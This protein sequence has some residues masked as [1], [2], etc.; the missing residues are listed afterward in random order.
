MSCLWPTYRYNWF[1]KFH[2]HDMSLW[3]EP[4]PGKLSD[5]DQDVLRGL[6]EYNPWK[7]TP[8]LALDL[9]TSQSIICYHFFQGREM[10]CFS[11]ISWQ[12]SKNIFFMT[13]FNEK[14][15]GLTRINLSSQPQRW[16]FI[17]ENL[18]WYYSFWVFKLKS[19]TKC[20]LILS[21]AGTCGWKFPKKALCFHHWEKCCD[22][23]WKHNATFSKNHMGKLLLYFGL[24]YPIHHIHQTLNQVISIFF[25]YKMLR[26]TKQFSKR[27]GENVCGKL[28]ELETSRILLERNQQAT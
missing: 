4:R 19:D 12:V 15:S 9:N 28:L 10:T 22:S 8:E 13:I 17:E 24:F 7:S 5:L 3:D 21:A 18:R 2:S 25:F 1:S 11:G 27:L 14:G 6:V 23:P 20:R 26:M 16:I